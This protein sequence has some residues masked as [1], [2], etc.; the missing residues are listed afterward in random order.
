MFGTDTVSGMEN[1]SADERESIVDQLEGN[2]LMKMFNID[3][4]S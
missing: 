1:I 4:S 3:M 2:R